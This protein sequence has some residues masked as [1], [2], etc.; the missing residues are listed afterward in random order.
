MGVDLTLVPI[1]DDSPRMPWWLEGSRLDLHRDYAV[2]N[3]IEPV[4]RIPDGVRFSRYSDEG[5]EDRNDD[6]YGNPLT[7][8]TAGDLAIVKLHKQ[9]SLWNQACWAFIRALPP[10][11][12]IVLW[13]H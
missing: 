4:K 6:Q 7:Y 9:A 11:T 10:K 5:I 3:L 8:I 13:W 12:K 2:W 1:R